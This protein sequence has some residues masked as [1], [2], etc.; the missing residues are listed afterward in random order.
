MVPLVAE[1]F[2]TLKVNDPLR[3]DFAGI[4]Q[5]TVLDIVEGLR[6]EG[7][8]NHEIAA[9][10]DLSMAGFYR[11]LKDLRETYSADDAGARRRM[12]LWEQ[13]YELVLERSGGDARQPVRY[14]TI[15]QAFPALTAERL[16]T[17]LRYLV[18][19]GHL[20]VTGHGATREY[21]LV[22]REPAGEATY[23]DAVVTLYRDGPLSLTDL[24]TRLDTPEATCR[25]YIER[26]GSAGKLETLQTAD[27]PALF[28]ATGY[29]IEPEAS[30]GYEAALY[31]HFQ[32][33]VR[34]IC[35]KI[36][37]KDHQ[38]RYA[39]LQG[40]TTFSLDV[41]VD[42]P[43]YAEISGFLAETR[44]KMERWLDYVTTNPPK[45]GQRAVTVTIYTGQSVEDL[46]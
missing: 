28:R 4:A 2:A 39:D 44:V 38:A 43:M 17:I 8:T 35:K 15:E 16:G 36:R 18:R 20:S 46:E 13:L 24:A 1:L 42:D 27:E 21:R 32:A 5:K 29:H 3:M 30:E 25:A 11:K 37:S 7:L 40:G 12:T 22:E 34:A 41:E 19:Y 31:D 10:L 6:T 14:V 9:A 23:H 45:T 33:V 26:L